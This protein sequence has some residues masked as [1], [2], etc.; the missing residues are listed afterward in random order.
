[1]TQPTQRETPL[2]PHHSALGRSDL[3]LLLLGQEIFVD[4]RNDTTSGN[5]GLDERVQLFI[6]SNSL[7]TDTNYVNMC[8][9]RQQ[10]ADAMAS[11]QLQMT[12]SN[13]LHFQVL[14]SIASQFQDF[15]GQILQN[16]GRIHSGLGSY[17]NIAGSLLL[18]QPVNTANGKLKTKN[19]PED[20]VKR[21]Q[22]NQQR[23]VM[24]VPVNQLSQN[25]R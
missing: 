5:G 7:T 13:S 21:T 16:G 19:K 2:Q 20:L 11:Y 24:T 1:M 10:T 3:F 8:V 25:E 12:G 22:S 17:S 18:Q 4:V 6:S 23:P 15:S 9:L 14:G